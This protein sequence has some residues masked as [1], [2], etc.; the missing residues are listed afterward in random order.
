MSGNTLGQV[1]KLRDT[2]PSPLF[3][4]RVHDQ[5][6]SKMRVDGP[7]EVQPLLKSLCNMSYTGM[8]PRAP[9]YHSVAL[10]GRGSVPSGQSV[11]L[12]SNRMMGYYAIRTDRSRISVS[13][14]ESITLGAGTGYPS[15][16][17]PL[18]VSV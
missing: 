5:T 12:P 6:L 9:R 14:M 11:S 16:P 2:Y 8:I 4:V 10:G 18:F 3:G 17:K 1:S 13:C 15:P 7:I